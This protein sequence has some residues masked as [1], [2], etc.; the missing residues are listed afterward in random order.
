MTLLYKGTDWNEDI[1]HRIYEECEVIGREE[2]K[3]DWYQNQFEIVDY[4]N[5]L[6]VYA[7]H[8]M[9]LMYNHWSFGKSYVQHYN[10]YKSGKMG[11]ALEMV[12]NSNPCI[13]YLL[14]ENTATGQ[15][16]VIAHAAIGHNSFFK[17]NYLFKQWT[18]ADYI[19]DYLD[20]AKKYVAKC[21]EKYGQEEVEFIL[22]AA[23][24]LM[25][26]GVDKYK[27]PKLLSPAEEELRRKERLEN[28][29][30]IQDDIWKIIPR[31]GQTTSWS[32]KDEFLPYGPEENLLYFLEKKSPILKNW[33]RELIRIVRK[34]ANY[35][36]PQYQSKIINEGWASTVH[37]YIMNRLYDKELLDN[38]A[39]L[40]FL[41]LHTAVVR[42]EPYHSRYYSGFNPYYLGF[43]IFKDIKRICQDPTKEDMD[44]FPDI[45]GSDWVETW[46][47][48]YENFRDD[49]FI[50][51]FLSPKLIRDMKLFQYSDE[52]EKDEY[53]IE[54][55][56]NDRG[57][58]DIRNT[59]AE[60]NSI[61]KMFPD[62][63]V[64]GVDFDTR[65]CFLTH[66]SDNGMVLDLD[67][68]MRTI[69]NFGY[70]WG[71]D[72]HLI[73]EERKTGNLLMEYNYN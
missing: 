14:D 46:K 5:M 24:S 9:P 68:A 38:G 57:Y 63:Q 30:K 10:L 20:F 13:N 19:I 12:I 71:F 56:H 17:N 6:N 53:E 34:V 62:I 21:E 29:E 47:Y 26:N 43:N 4:E 51:Q 54:K 36:S 3:L 40:E 44:W 8:G 49:S 22:D 15:A 18:A 35:F 58:R 45:A 67:D 2:L 23:H 16:L 1:L 28:E 59:L 33:Q 32:Y 70:L 37:Y 69:E 65:I 73:S 72:V 39:M 64:T 27:K 50:Q 61:G 7:S 66:Y 25:T 31:K 60:S 42:Q 52:E 55:I 48:A 41:S 11:L